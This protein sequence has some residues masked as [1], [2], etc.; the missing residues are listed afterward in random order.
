MYGPQP[1]Y[2]IPVQRPGLL[3]A[4]QKVAATAAAVAL[5][6][7]GGAA[8]AVGAVALTGSEG[9]I[10]APVTVSGVS[11]TTSI[12]DI[13]KAVQPGVVSISA[14]SAR[15]SATGSGVV[16]RSDGTIVTNNHVIEGASQITV[17]FSDGGSAP[18]RVVG[19]S[20]GNDLAV[21]KAE[22]VTGKTAVQVADS[23]SA[24]VGDTVVALG[25]PLGLDGSVT[26][27][28]VSAKNRTVAESE[29]ATIKGAIQTDAAINPGNSGGALVDGTGALI[30]IN[31]AIATTGEASGSIGVG[32]AI[33]SN[34]VKTVVSQ[35]LSGNSTGA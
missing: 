12:S 20:P 23:D 16:L 22:G 15:E 32:F 7:G 8:G 24:V 25:S 31:T 19:T 14:E 11:R 26:S 1:N 4:R 35:I 29:G 5:A 2:R 27:G 30:G 9:G 33:P 34:T 10:K 21:I 18:A 28:I 13:A 6:L 17:K 3:S